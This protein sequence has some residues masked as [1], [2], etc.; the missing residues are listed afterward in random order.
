MPY[1]TAQLISRSTD[2]N[3]AKFIAGDYNNFILQVDGNKLTA[4]DCITLRDGNTVCGLVDVNLGVVTHTILADDTNWET[5]WSTFDANMKSYY[6]QKSDFNADWNASAVTQVCPAG[7]ALQSLGTSFA[8]VAV[9]GTDTNWSTGWTVFDANM[10]N[11]FLT[12]SNPAFDGNMD[13]VD[14]NIIY[15]PCNGDIE[16]YVTNAQAKDT[17]VLGSC[18][19]NITDDIDVTKAVQIKGQGQSRT[20]IAN[21]TTG[22]NLFHITTDNV[23][24]KDLSVTST[25]LSG[26]T[27]RAIYVDATAGDVFTNVRVINVDI[28]GTSTGGAL[29][30]IL[31]D[32]AGGTIK[33]VNVDQNCQGSTNNGI[34]LRNNASAET[35]TTL[36]VYNTYV[37]SSGVATTNYG[38]SSQDISATQDGFLYLYDSKSFVSGATTNYGLYASSGDAYTYAYSTTFSGTQGDVVVS[39]SAVVQLNNCTLVNGLMSGGQIET[40][41]SNFLEKMRLASE[42]GVVAGTNEQIHLISDRAAIVADNLLGGIDVKSNDTS[43]SGGAQ[44]SSAYLRF[45]ADGTHTA[46]SLASKLD[47]LLTPANSITPVSVFRVDSS[48]GVDLNQVNVTY[49]PI[50]GSINTY[51]TNATAGDTLIL[52]SGTYAITS[53]IAANKAINIVGHGVGQTTISTSTNGINAITVTADNVSI[54]NLSIVH[55]GAGTTNN[56]IKV[57]ATAGTIFSN[58]RVFNVNVSLSGASTNNYGIFYSDAGGEVKDVKIDV[59][60]GT[61]GYGLLFQ[62]SSTA[63]ADTTLRVT[64]AR[65]SLSGN[66]TISD[67]FYNLDNGASVDS[68]LYLYNCYGSSSAGSSSYGLVSNGLDSFVYAY[69]S[70]FSGVTA[71]TF[72]SSTATLQL[73]NCTLLNNTT[74]GTISYDGEIRSEDLY[75]SDNATILG[76]ATWLSDNGSAI[77]GAGS[78]ASIKYDG[79]NLLINPQVVGTGATIFTG[80]VGIGTTSPSQK[81][82]VNGNILL[83]DNNKIMFGDASDAT[84]SYGGVD[85]NINPK[86]VGSGKVNIQGNLSIDENFTGKNLTTTTSASIPRLSNLTTDGYVTTSGGNGTLGVSTPAIDVNSFWR[87]NGT[88]VAN[89]VGKDIDVNGKQIINTVSNGD[90]NLQINDGGTT[91]TAIQV[92]G[93]E[94]SVTMP[95]QSYVLVNR[96]STTGDQVIAHNTWTTVIFDEEIVDTLGEYNTTTGIFTAKDDGVYQVSA[97]I[98][99]ANTNATKQYR[100]AIIT[101]TN[102]Y[103]PIWVSTANESYHPSHLSM[104]VKLTAGQTIYIQAYQDSGGNESLTAP[105]DTWNNLTITKVS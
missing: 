8:C 36:K 52:S 87:D 99:W 18:T 27:N 73:S 98:V 62:N 41:T 26:G 74:S 34:L 1:N 49:V 23:T 92:N 28:T 68:F 5:S 24:I 17:L 69:N 6:E 104:S 12:K 59:T 94:G 39:S 48:G 80:N 70:V 97:W 37:T 66:A 90:L 77:F 105:I 85:L 76:D 15:V 60:A 45:L 58:V 13:F 51:I 57:D 33:N 95:R 4:N 103:P 11:Y 101:P 47:L 78:D 46:T 50:G 93:D 29:A 16:T 64:N 82:H 102:T 65:V 10:R 43:L 56:G 44:T 31:Y 72:K 2:L 86:S 7:Q 32:D 63:E 22:K 75:L 19:Y 38:F 84:I 53:A 100:I 9:G 21:S 88:S 79:T 54:R 42:S 83:N 96:N 3:Y 14:G 55:T 67:A 89:I 91:R 20:T 71:D 30:A 61:N 40:Y 35:T 81:L 25:S